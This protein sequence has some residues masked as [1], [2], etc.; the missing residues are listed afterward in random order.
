MKYLILLTFIILF[1]NQ[2]AGTKNKHEVKKRSYNEKEHHRPCLITADCIDTAVS[3]MKLLKD[4]I[5]NFEKQLS[6]M[7]TQNKTG[8]SKAGKKGIFES[9]IRRIVRAG[10]GNASNLTC[11]G[12]AK[13]SGAEKLK[14]LATL[15][16]GCEVN[17]KNSCDTLNLPQP[18]ERKV[19]GK[20]FHLELHLLYLF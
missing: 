9:I 15:L 1:L 17:I 4:K 13:S 18:N 20:I 14:N 7:K 11:N 6:R 16:M 10:G 8:K 12:K 2:M 5:S 19:S 3:Y